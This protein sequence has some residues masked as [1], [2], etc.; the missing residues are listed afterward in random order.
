MPRSKGIGKPKR[1]TYQQTP[2]MAPTAME[3][4]TT[5]ATKTNEMVTINAYESSIEIEVINYYEEMKLERQ[6]KVSR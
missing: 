3:T 5:M 2:P 6:W 4:A 1:R